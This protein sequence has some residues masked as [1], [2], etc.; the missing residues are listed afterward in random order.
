M[1]W[2]ELL[3]KDN[4]PY[5]KAKVIHS[6]QLLVVT[7]QRNQKVSSGQVEHILLIGIIQSEKPIACKML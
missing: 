3:R 7:I 2:T 6:M 5:C 4:L 1:K